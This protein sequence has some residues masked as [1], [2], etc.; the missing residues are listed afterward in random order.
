MKRT[1]Y[2]HPKIFPFPMK[3]KLILFILCGI[4]FTSCVAVKPYERMYLND[5]EMSLE[6]NSTDMFEGYVHS[7]R[8]G[9]TPAATTKS[10]G[11]CGCN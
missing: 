1:K 5:S 6:S 2:I 11:G 10:S 9:I 7:I 8:E 3:P 4:L